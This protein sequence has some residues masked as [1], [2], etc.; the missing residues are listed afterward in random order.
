MNFDIIDTVGAGVPHGRFVIEGR[1]G[2]PLAGLHFAA[3]DLFDVAGLPTG[4]GNPTG[5]PPTPCPPGT[6]R[7]WRNCWTPAPR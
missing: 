3:K 6:A 1:A 4:A 7:W 2:A 5:W